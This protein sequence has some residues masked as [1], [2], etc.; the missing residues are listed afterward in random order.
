MGRG[1]AILDPRQARQSRYKSNY[2]V[3]L[4][5]RHVASQHFEL[6]FRPTAILVLTVAMT[7]PSGQLPAGRPPLP[8]QVQHQ[9][10]VGVSASHPTCTGA[11][12]ESS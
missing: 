11:L 6:R 7:L 1:C 3:D 2:G 5:H 10:A 9:P 12:T 8:K 4:S